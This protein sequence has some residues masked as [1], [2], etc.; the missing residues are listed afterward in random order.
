MFF[1]FKKY[2]KIEKVKLENAYK[3]IK[4]VGYADDERFKG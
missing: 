3:I 1:Y 2:P 4:Y